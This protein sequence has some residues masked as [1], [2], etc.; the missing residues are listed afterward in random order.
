MMPVAGGAR[1]PHVCLGGE[2][3][4]GVLKHLIGVNPDWRGDLLFPV[5]QQRT[6][7][8]PPVC[9]ANVF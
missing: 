8:M 4:V 5:G 9:R 6:P 7:G 1:W 3:R 2:V